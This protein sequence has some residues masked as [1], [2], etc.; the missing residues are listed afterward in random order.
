MTIEIIRK[1]IKDLGE[2]PTGVKEKMT[3]DSPPMFRLIKDPDALTTLARK[4]IQLSEIAVDLEADSMFHY[5]ERVC[6]LQMATAEENVIIDPLAVETLPCLKPIFASPDIRKIFHGADYDIRSL[7]RDFGIEIRNLF[8]TQL[9]SRF[10]GMKET[11]LEALIRDHF[12]VSL[13]KRFQKKNWSERPLSDEMLTY[14][15]RDT[16]YLIPLARILESRLKAAGRWD[17][18]TEECALLTGVRVANNDAEPLFLRFKGAGRLRGRS[19]AVLES[20]L[21]LRKEIAEKKDRPVFKV[22]SSETISKIVKSKP[23]TLNRLEKTQA[24]SRKQLNMHGLQI[25]AAVAAGMDV[26]EE[27][28]PVYPRKKAPRL[29]P[30]VPERIA[31]LK[32]WRQETA[33]GLDIEP[34][35]VLSKS[36]MGDIAQKNPRRTAELEDIEEMRN[37]QRQEFGASILAVLATVAPVKPKRPRRRYR[38]KKRDGD[39]GTV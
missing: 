34:S 22:F 19:L 8:D 17:W 32:K 38:R 25:V 14:A 23:L 36:L 18:V 39:A 33:E 7:N 3:G 28:L 27:A 4:W 15:A 31:A 13:D 1:Q 16:A 12:D 9:A 37:W 30:R 2:M 26:P 20:V 5:H 6:L 24:L 11:S 35:L 29:G 21:R 10:L